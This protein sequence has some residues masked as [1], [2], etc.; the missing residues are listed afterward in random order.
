M[1]FKTELNAYQREAVE[2]VNGPLLVLAGAGSGKTR[3]ITYRI[4]YLIEEIGVSPYNILSITFTNKAA[5]EMKERVQQLILGG[6]SSD[7]WVSTF[8]SACARILRMEIERLGF[9]KNFVIFDTAD[10]L[11]LIREC[12]RELNINEKQFSE[13]NISSVIG[14]AKDNL[15]TSADFE[16]QAEGNFRLSIIADVYKLYQKKLKENNALDFDDLIMRTIE[17]FT[18]FP[19]VLKHYQDRFLYIMVDEY[20]DTNYS[21][22]KLVRMLSEKH[23][24]LCVVGDDD[25][26]IY[27]WRGANIRNI[28]EFEKDYPDAKVVKLEQ[29]YRSSQNILNAANEVIANNFKRKGKALWT[30]KGSGEKIKVVCAPDEHYEAQF[31]AGEIMKLTEGNHIFRDCAVLYRVHAQS[32][33]IEDT[34]MKIGIPYM[35]VGGLRFYERK[36]IKDIIAYLRVISNPSDNISLLRILNVPRRGIGNVSRGKLMQFAEETGESLFEII[37]KPERISIIGTATIKRINEF[38]NLL[39]Y[40]IQIK[41]KTTISGLIH[42]VLDATGYINELELEDTA[43]SRSRLENLKEFFSAADE[44]QI[45]YPDQGLEEFLIHISLITDIDDVKDNENAVLLM[46]LHGAK[47]LEFPNVFICGMEEGLFPHSRSLTEADELDEERRLCYVG[48]TRAEVNLYLTYAQ[49]RSMYG[50]TTFNSA[51]RFLDEIPQSLI[52]YID[53]NEP[54]DSLSGLE[55]VPGERVF[56]EKW[57]SGKVI[58]VN[59]TGYDQELFV[60]FGEDIGIKHLI[61]RYAPI[62]RR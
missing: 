34:F 58:N 26:S 44:F 59:G 48:M 56:H 55:F 36:E 49:Q 1:D 42:E 33:V 7:I 53:M 27:Q 24:N 37:G 30:R 22:Y 21:Q 43:V 15:L 9:N 11:S 19:D 52:E 20:Q 35:I 13:R 62:I 40:F 46:T 29:N 10:Q 47:G 12:L 38:R 50:N 16:R 4:A 8:H 3:V 23:R 57:G 31:I 14:S 54:N 32:R 51:S 45:M 41:D 17:L 2:H 60:D 6:K 18:Y 28:L 5:G 61:L 25:Q 39:D